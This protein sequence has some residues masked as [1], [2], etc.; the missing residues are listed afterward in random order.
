M[1]V[2]KSLYLCYGKEDYMKK[3]YI[4]NIKNKIIDPSYEIMNL[5]RHDGKGVSI[6]QIIDFAE[7]MPFMS[8]RR[9][10]II[11]DSGLFKS[12]KKDESDKL[13]SY[14]DK[15]PSSVC[16]IFMES[17]IDKR[18]S[19]YK[20]TNKD[21]TA[22]EFKI[23]SDKELV[24][25]TKKELIRYNVRMSNS[26]IEYFVRVVPPG[27]ESIINEI[28]KLAAYNPEGEITREAIDN[29]CTHSL[30]I[31]IFELVKM[32]GN[33]DTKGVLE[34]YTN[35]LEMK[36]SPIGI[37]AM[38]SRQF[39]MI[40]KVKYM[41]QKGHDNQSIAARTG[42]RSF[43]I[44]ECV[45]QASNFTFSQLESAI[46]ECLDADVNIKTGMMKPEL[47]VELILIKYASKAL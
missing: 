33:K 2:I 27:M 42:F 21:H 36:E 38:M 7:T 16:I 15:L 30:D 32:L 22:I 4:E 10:M 6:D 26:L 23:P 35:L 34:I 43:M 8:E 18:L 12:G 44:T 45:N 25:W 46:K 20:K 41:K 13:A 14:I 11:K 31:R 39:R 3:Q 29:V 40:L 37:L 47:A 9:L 19:V 5:E 24:Q 1:E 17:E 28:K